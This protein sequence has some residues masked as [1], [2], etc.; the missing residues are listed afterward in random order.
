MVSFSI[1][2]RPGNLMVIPTYIPNPAYD[3]G[4]VDEEIAAIV[5]PQK[6]SLAKTYFKKARS[7]SVEREHPL[8]LT[9]ACQYMPLDR[10]TY[11]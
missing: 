1:V 3:E 2:R 5:R 11:T 9:K 6:L 10:N 4:S 7:T 8:H